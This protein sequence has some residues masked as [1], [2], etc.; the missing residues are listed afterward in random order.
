[1][2]DTP[3]EFLDLMRRVR[4]RDERAAEELY[5]RY[6]LTFSRLSA[7]AC[8]SRCGH[9]FR[10]DRLSP[11]GLDSV[12]R[13]CNPCRHLPRAQGTAGL[14]RQGS[15]GKVAGAYRRGLQTAKYQLHRSAHEPPRDD[16]PPQPSLAASDPTPS[17]EAVAHEG[18]QSRWTA[19]PLLSVTYSSCVVKATPTKRSPAC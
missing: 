6:G 11:V 16:G 15:R 18:W 8:T 9:P 1:M 19:N 10:L 2:A 12:L 5:H 3:G 4:E 13:R 17:Q 7:V 14:P